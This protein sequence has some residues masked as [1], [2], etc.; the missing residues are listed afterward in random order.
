MAETIGIFSLNN[1]NDLLNKAKYQFSKLP[2]INKKS[3][4]YEYKIWDICCTLYHIKDWI[5][6][7]TSLNSIGNTEQDRANILNKYFSTDKVPYNFDFC[8]IQTLCIRSKHFTQ[9]QRLTSKNQKIINQ[10]TKIA[11]SGN[12][13]GDSY[14][15]DSQYGTDLTY[16][17]EIDNQK[18]DLINI[19]KNVIN[20]WEIFFSNAKSGNL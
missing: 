13:Y 16:I 1:Y 5:K 14:Y 8:I 17:I 9:D 18:Y 20:A 6:K 11:V 19:F 7:D 3:K 4:E 12:Y 15:G 10:K 2:N